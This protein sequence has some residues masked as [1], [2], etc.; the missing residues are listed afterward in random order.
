MISSHSLPNLHLGYTLLMY[1]TAWW[2]HLAAEL[3]RRQLL[4]QK[5]R[6]QPV[7][8]RQQKAAIRQPSRCPLICQLAHQQMMK[9]KPLAVSLPAETNMAGFASRRWRS[10]QA[11][12]R[13]FK[14]CSRCHRAP[15]VDRLWVEGLGFRIT[16][17][18]CH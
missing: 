16:L 6:P 11:G 5:R 14:Y 9:G 12:P 10:C 15:V 8:R 2:D 17:T 3:P 1:A 7:P 13:Q 4:F 18:A